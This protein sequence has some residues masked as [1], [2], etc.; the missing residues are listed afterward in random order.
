MAQSTLLRS[1][2]VR[3]RVR[4]Y[5]PHALYHSYAFG[6]STDTIVQPSTTRHITIEA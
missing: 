4:L 6:L 5:R 1:T 2:Q 3:R